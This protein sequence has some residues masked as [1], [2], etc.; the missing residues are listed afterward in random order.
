LIGWS[1]TVN[2]PS[3]E[4][5]RDPARAAFLSAYLAGSKT[6]TGIPRWKFSLS[7]I[8]AMILGNVVRHLLVSRYSLPQPEATLLFFIAVILF[9]LLVGFALGCFSRR[10][11]P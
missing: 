10:E 5:E 3:D 11:I 7:V 4:P 9:A 8:L 1:K 2:P 6:V